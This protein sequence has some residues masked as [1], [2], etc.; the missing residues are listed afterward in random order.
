MNIEATSDDVLHH[1]S[2]E[3]TLKAKKAASIQAERELELNKVREQRPWDQ[4][5][6]VVDEIYQVLEQQ[7]PASTSAEDV[8]L[9]LDDYLDKKITQLK[10][11]N[12]DP[13]ELKDVLY[14]L[15]ADI[16]LLYETS[17]VD[18]YTHQEALG[19]VMTELTQLPA[20]KSEVNLP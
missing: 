5:N 15:L 4:A 6:L 3:S 1:H 16:N 2:P 17:T 8:S 13:R 18:R 10:E 12:L 14:F 20:F 11:Q 9:V 7:R 19:R